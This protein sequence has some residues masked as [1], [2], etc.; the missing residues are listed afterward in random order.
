M[1]TLCGQ[2]RPAVQVV[3]LWEV[4]GRQRSS[5]V[6]QV[7]ASAAG[8]GRCEPGTRVETMEQSAAEEAVV[9]D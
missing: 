9:G 7:C 2:K 4:G 6:V 8:S 1:C 3:C 5:L